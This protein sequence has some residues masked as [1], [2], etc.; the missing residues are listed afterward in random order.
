MRTLRLRVSPA[1]ILSRECEFELRS[2]ISG[3]L[4]RVWNTEFKLQ[5][6]LLDNFEIRERIFWAHWR[7]L[8]SRIA[9]RNLEMAAAV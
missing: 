2:N 8:D 9:I 3:A 1:S 5:A 6:F 7:F 4:E